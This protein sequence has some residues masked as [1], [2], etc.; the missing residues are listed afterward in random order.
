M[1]PDAKPA[2]MGNPPRRGR[3]ASRHS[4]DANG[5]SASLQRRLSKS[6]TLAGSPCRRPRSLDRLNRDA[7]APNRTVHSTNA[8]DRLFGSRARYGGDGRAPAARLR[9]HAT[10]RPAA[11]LVRTMA[12]AWPG[13]TDTKLSRSTRSP[14][15]RL[16]NQV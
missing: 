5:G 3:D 13:R 14:R 8:L 11:L 15:G 6:S 12:G 16:P 10:D 2:A 7:R 9:A 4:A 1:D